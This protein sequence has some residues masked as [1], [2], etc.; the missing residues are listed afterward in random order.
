MTQ[1]DLAL[2]GRAVAAN[3]ANS[4]RLTSAH[5]SSRGLHMYIEMDTAMPLT[6]QFEQRTRIAISCPAVRQLTGHGKSLAC[7]PCDA[8]SEE[9]Q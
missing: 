1:H 7:A 5:G 4:Y 8:E 2:I 3:G 6:I 9:L